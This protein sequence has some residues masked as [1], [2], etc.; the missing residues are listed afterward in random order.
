MRR[1]SSPT[2][3]RTGTSR[4]ASQPRPRW[5]TFRARRPRSFLTTGAGVA[6]PFAWVGRVHGARVV[7]VESLTRIDDLSLTYRLVRPIVTGSTFSGPS[8]RATSPGS[9]T[10]PPSSASDLRHRRDDEAPFDRLVRA[11][12][13]FPGEELVVQERSSSIR[14]ANATWLDYCRS[15]CSSITS[16]GPMSSSPTRH[17]LDD[18]RARE[19]KATDRR[20]GLQRFG[21]AV[22]D[23][24]IALARRLAEKG[25]ISS[26]S[27]SA[28]CRTRSP[29]RHRARSRW[30][31][32][33]AEQELRAHLESLVRGRG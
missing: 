22:D 25:A 32:T 19:R 14:P 9:S 23:H 26:S 20:A 3:R 6:V 30:A 12:S 2:G 10:R 16:D 1:S 28:S 8:S 33:A 24:Q 31:T 11:S 21:E 15:R 5:R 18:R 29:R 4:T 17:R 27:R 13:A 7:Y